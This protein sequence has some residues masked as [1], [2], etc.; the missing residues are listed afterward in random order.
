[1]K[2]LDLAIN[3][4]VGLLDIPDLTKMSEG[5]MYSC[6]VPLKVTVRGA[7]EKL[8]KRMVWGIPYTLAVSKVKF[9]FVCTKRL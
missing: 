9:I 7:V 4:L 3:D 6:F 1:M 2:R 5:R 8:M